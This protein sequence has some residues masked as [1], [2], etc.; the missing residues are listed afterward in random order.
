MASFGIPFLGL[1]DLSTTNPISLYST[2]AVV[3]SSLLYYVGW[4]AIIES[5]S[6]AVVKPTLIFRLKGKQ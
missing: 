3:I 2:I 4:L 1:K 5:L 6:T